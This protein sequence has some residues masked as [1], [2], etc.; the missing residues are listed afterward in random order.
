MSKKEIQAQR[1]N[2]TESKPLFEKVNYEIMIIGLA[3]IFL[4]YIIMSVETEVNGLGFLGL[5]LGPIFLLI[6]FGTEFIA[7]LYKPKNKKNGTA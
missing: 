4:G 7:I 5:T 1:K 2:V 3:V 6:G